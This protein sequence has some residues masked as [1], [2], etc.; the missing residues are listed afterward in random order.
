M[1]GTDAWFVWAAQIVNFL[2][3]VALLRKF[4][5]RRV[6]EAIASRQQDIAARVAEAEQTR[7]E[8]EQAG[9]DLPGTRTG[10]QSR[11]RHDVRRGPARSR[12]VEAK[13]PRTGP[14]TKSMQIQARW[15][16]A[17][18]R[19]RGR[20]LKELRE[21]AGRQVH[22]VVRHV[23]SEL[24]DANLERQLVGGVYGSAQIVGSQP[25]GNAWPR[26]ERRKPPHHRHQRPAACRGIASGTSADRS[27]QNFGNVEP[28]RF[29]VDADLICGMELQMGDQRL[30]WNVADTI[31][32]LERNF[33]A[34][35]D[36][37]HAGSLAGETSS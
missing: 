34:A 13:G 15:W 27:A 33:A 20:F 35:L 23:L 2:I 4:L 7:R 5:Y 31:E 21:R 32:T 37:D 8:A 12:P 16:E 36:H 28:I 29:E 17:L 30:S 14:A 19:D 10:T 3:L 24:A 18:D 22:Q 25:R 11:P 9:R 6:L 1:P 26:T